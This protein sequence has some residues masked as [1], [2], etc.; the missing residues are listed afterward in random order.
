MA[1]VRALHLHDPVAAGRGARHA[2]GVHR[3]LGAG[4]HEAHLLPA[5]PPVDLL[6]ERNRLRGGHGEVRTGRDR[7]RHR[8][9][10]LRVR[11][12]D[13]VHPE[14]A[15]EASP[16]EIVEAHDLVG[17]ARTAMASLTPGQRAALELAYFQGKTSAEVA[18][19]EGIPIGTAKTRIRTAL[20]KI[21]EVLV[22]EH[23]L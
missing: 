21:R 14:A 12:P 9:D 7:L 17:R 5:E 16:E 11:M 23:E 18:E 20:A 3:G 13:H 19:L 15:V 1:V 22:V 10:D 2:D 6:G 4:V 8:F